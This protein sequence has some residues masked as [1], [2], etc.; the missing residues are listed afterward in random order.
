MLPSAKA[1]QG[2]AEGIADLVED[3][4]Q[5]QCDR[6]TDKGKNKEGVEVAGSGEWSQKNIEDRHG[7]Q[8]THIDS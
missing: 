6:Q 5:N 8:E 4:H 2:V 3:D 1:K 7:P